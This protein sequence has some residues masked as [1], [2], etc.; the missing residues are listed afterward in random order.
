MNRLT[1][2]DLPLIKVMLQRKLTISDEEVP[3]H[4]R[5]KKVMNR[6][7]ISSKVVMR[8]INDVP[9][10]T[11]RAV[12]RK[13]TKYVLSFAEYPFR[14]VK[15]LVELDMVVDRH[16]LDVEVARINVKF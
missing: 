8:I 3:I 1:R 15:L 5:N 2:K 9:I 6:Y 11:I 4:P 13:G 10:H 12:D 7:G 16:G 14:T